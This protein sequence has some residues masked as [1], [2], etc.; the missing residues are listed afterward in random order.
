MADE[1]AT[2][3][4]ITLETYIRDLEEMV[5]SAAED[6]DRLRAFAGELYDIRQAAKIARDKHSKRITD[7][8]IEDMTAIS[9]RPASG[10]SPRPGP[11][12]FLPID[13]R[14]P[15]AS[16]RSSNRARCRTPRQISGI[17]WESWTPD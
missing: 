11:I 3:D 16:P 13:S 4:P 14:P 2:I 12:G 6:L 5:A 17:F 15:N 10:L 8:T 9:R 7:E 1:A